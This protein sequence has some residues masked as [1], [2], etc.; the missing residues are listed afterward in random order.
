MSEPETTPQDPTPEAPKPSK[1]GLVLA[2]LA[3][4]LAVILA[5]AAGDVA[6]ARTA[7]VTVA[8]MLLLVNAEE[9]HP[10]DAVKAE[11]ADAPVDPALLSDEAAPAAAPPA[12]TSTPSD[13]E[14]AP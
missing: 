4:L 14:V 8:P 13:A 3:G 11:P 12:P 6:G 9:A 1:R 5:L 10:V 7:L 2:I